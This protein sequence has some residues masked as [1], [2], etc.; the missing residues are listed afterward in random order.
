[1]GLA[2]EPLV[3]RVAHDL[4]LPV[5][6]PCH[7]SAIEFEVVAA[8]SL[9][10][11]SHILSIPIG[12]GDGRV[13]S[14]WIAVPIKSLHVTLF[15]IAQDQPDVTTKDAHPTWRA[16]SFADLVRVGRADSVVSADREVM[17]R[18]RPAEY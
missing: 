15:R 5:L 6:Q 1:L 10:E 11:A 18:L 17:L 4:F 2:P 8:F 12:P 16:S 13:A 9:E 14:D 7:K 3:S